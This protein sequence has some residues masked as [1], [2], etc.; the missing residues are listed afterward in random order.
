[1]IWCEICFEV[2]HNEHALKEHLNKFETV[3]T[4]T[5][6]KNGKILLNFYL[7][8]LLIIINN[9]SCYVIP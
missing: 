3:D 9:F 1:M 4:L 5:T 6:E 2:F 8:D 7:F